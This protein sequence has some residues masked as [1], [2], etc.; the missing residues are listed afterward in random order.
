MILHIYLAKFTRNRSL[1][2]ENKT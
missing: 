1:Q 2:S